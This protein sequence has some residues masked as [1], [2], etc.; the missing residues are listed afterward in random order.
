MGCPSVCQEY[1]FIFLLLKFY[2]TLKKIIKIWN[3]QQKVRNWKNS[4]FSFLCTSW[5]LTVL[6]EYKYRS[7]KGNMQEGRGSICAP[8]P[9]YMW[10]AWPLSRYPCP[11]EFIAFLLFLGCCSLSLVCSLV[12]ALVGVGHTIVSCSL[13]FNQLRISIMVSICY[14]KNFF[15]DE[16]WDLLLYVG[17]RISI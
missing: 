10:A 13:H 3:F 5:Y 4:M 8:L 17:I 9:F 1:G 7:K 2:S 6:Y 14:K 16:G 11:L 15:A 12:N